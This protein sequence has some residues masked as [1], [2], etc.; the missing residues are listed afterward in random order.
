[1]VS[2][3]WAKSLTLVNVLA[4]SNMMADRDMS[5]V[6]ETQ[7]LGFTD[8]QGSDGYDTGW[9]KLIK[10]HDQASRWSIIGAE[11]AKQVANKAEEA[12]AQP[13]TPRQD[14]SDGRWDS[15]TQN[16]PACR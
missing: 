15:D 5:D 13:V 1:M 2:F 7:M 6:C 10:A 3:N 14:E 11:V 12:A 8:P 9:L 16:T 4:K